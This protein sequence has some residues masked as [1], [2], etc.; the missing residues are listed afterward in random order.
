MVGGFN[1]ITMG[2]VG[3]M[4]VS[5]FAFYPTLVSEFSP[6]RESFSPSPPP[7]Y[8]PS[9]P[10]WVRSN[11]DWVIISGMQYNIWDYREQVGPV[12]VLRAQ[13]VTQQGS[14]AVITDFQLRSRVLTL[15]LVIISAQLVANLYAGAQTAVIAGT[16]LSQVG[17]LLKNVALPT[18]VAASL[19]SLQ[20]L[21]ASGGDK[22]APIVNAIAVSGSSANA[23]VS[24]HTDTAAETYMDAITA[25]SI[26]ESRLVAVFFVVQAAAQLGVPIGAW[27]SQLQADLDQGTPLL[28]GLQDTFGSLVAVGVPG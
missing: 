14:S 28:T 11:G 20:S 24:S 19:E 25:G 7:A 4:L 12:Q 10:N 18:D 13:V 5:L 8:T 16:A 22:A 23:L 21:L 27:T 6:S 15:G 2:L 9:D 3:A 17:S 26:P 1:P